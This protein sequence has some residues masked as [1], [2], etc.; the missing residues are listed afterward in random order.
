MPQAEVCWLRNSNRKKGNMRDIMCETPSPAA[1]RTQGAKPKVEL[2]GGRQICHL[3]S[4]RRA[5]GERPGTQRDPRAET[6]TRGERELR[7]RR[8][9]TRGEQLSCEQDQDLSRRPREHNHKPQLQY[10][11]RT[12]RTGTGKSLIKTVFKFN[13][14]YTVL[15]LAPRFLRVKNAC[16]QLMKGAASSEHSH[17]CSA[18]SP[19]RRGTGTHAFLS[20]GAAE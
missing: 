19:A 2:L 17:G 18:C 5:P 10:Q 7:A 9:K 4:Y 6:R 16:P 12:D 15:F 14:N 8:R 3:G 13:A 20:R 11:L 1:A